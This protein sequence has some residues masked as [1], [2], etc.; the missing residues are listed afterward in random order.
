MCWRG[1]CFGYS[2]GGAGGASGGEE[3]FSV[4]LP[5]EAV[6]LGGPAYG[7]GSVSDC[8]GFDEV[9]AEP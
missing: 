6:L 5:A 2:K 4:Q 3:L 7:F 9:W 8:K 1:G